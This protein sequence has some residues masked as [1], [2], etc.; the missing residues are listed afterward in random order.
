MSK[1]PSSSRFRIRIVFADNHMIGP[2]KMEL[3]ERIARTGSIAAAGREM[4]MSY[5]RAWQIVEALNATFKEPLVLT[6]RG[7]AQ[8]GGTT[9]TE[10]GEAVLRQYRMIEAEAESACKDNL[11]HLEALLKDV[12]ESR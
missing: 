10:S 12:P 2:G 5:K 7:G 11:R 3:L 9:L 4:R 1:Q 6:T 8:H